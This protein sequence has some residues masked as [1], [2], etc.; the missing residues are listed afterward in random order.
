VRPD[1]I[2]C[3]LHPDFASTRLAEKFAAEWNAHLVRVQHHHAHV[4]SVLGEHGIEDDVFA[5]VWD[6]YGF[7]LDGHAWGGEALVVRPGTFQRVGHLQPFRLPGG[8]KAAAEPR[9]SALG[10]LA[11]TLGKE[12][13]AVARSAWPN[14]S[15]DALWT[16]SERGFAAPWTSS[17]GRLFDAVASLLDIRHTCSYEGQA[18]M[19]LE[20]SAVT[21][22][23]HWPDPYLIPLSEGTPWTA[24]LGPLVEGLLADRRRGMPTAEIAA[25]FIA[26]LVDLGVRQCQ[27]AGLSNVVLAGG[28]FQNDLLTRA[29]V[30][31]LEAAGFEPLLPRQVPINDGGISAGQIAVASR[32]VVRHGG[33]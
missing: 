21:N 6:G 11:A 7:G 31:R 28:C 8:D 17:M 24:H 15:A 9:R 33:V 18:A 12:G 26:S 22:Q 27:R 29:L 32:V 13:L 1:V 10:L 20:W 16:A 30:K 4:A 19:E 3:D 23:G 25:R 2:A 5:L 14:G